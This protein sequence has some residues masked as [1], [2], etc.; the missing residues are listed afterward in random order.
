MPASPPIERFILTTFRSVWA[1]EVLLHLRRASEMPH[2]RA[3]LI[4][5]LRASDVVMS[6]SVDELV[7]A[8]LIVELG[9]G[10]LK[11]SP[12]SVDLETKVAAAEQLYKAKPDAVRR[13]IITSS[14][15][16]LAAFADAF[17]LKGDAGT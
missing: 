7:A 12:V 16:G 15:G 10:S 2:T 13:L 3:H 14:S 5:Q 8:A 11:Y 6:K 4:Q 9:D 17:R 1:L